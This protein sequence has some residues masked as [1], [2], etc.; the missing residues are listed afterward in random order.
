M[1]FEEDWGWWIWRGRLL[2][3]FFSMSSLSVEGCYKNEACDGAGSL[4]HTFYQSA[5][6]WV[7]LPTWCPSILE[8]KIWV[9]IGVLIPLEHVATKL[10]EDRQ[11]DRGI[12]VNTSHVRMCLVELET[13]I[14][15]HRV[16]WISEWSGLLNTI[17]LLNRITCKPLHVFGS[18]VKVLG[19]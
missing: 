19:L 6:G 16:I 8:K 15:T 17:E 10:E 9:G 4:V 7:F 2:F 13:L 11:S 14:E 18:E 5:L 1:S 3:T 12:R